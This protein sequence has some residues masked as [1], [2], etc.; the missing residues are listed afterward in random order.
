MANPGH[1]L[2]DAGL[3][4][5]ED[6]QRRASGP[7]RRRQSRTSRTRQGYAESSSMA[8][9][10]A[11]AATTSF[12]QFSGEG[13]RYESASSR[14]SSLSSQQSF[15]GKSSAADDDLTGIAY[16]RTGRISKAKKG[17][18]V[19]ECDRCDKVGFPRAIDRSKPL[20]SLSSSACVGRRPRSPERH[21]SLPAAEQRT[22]AHFSPYINFASKY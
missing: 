5:A 20:H 3:P 10:A 18:R 21:C 15:G 6:G 12:A 4:A 19:H 13:G 14:T 22:H 16:T 9:A 1:R 17:Q 8:A 2:T 7:Q 11:A